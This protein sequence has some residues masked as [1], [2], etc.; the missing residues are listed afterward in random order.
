MPAAWHSS[1]LQGGLGKGLCAAG[2]KEIGEAERIVQ[3]KGCVRDLE[4]SGHCLGVICV[5]R[6]QD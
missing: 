2:G 1:G 3:G 5:Y 6:E 4:K